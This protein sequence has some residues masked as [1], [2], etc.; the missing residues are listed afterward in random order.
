MRNYLSLAVLSLAASLSFGAEQTLSET[1]AVPTSL[2]VN[3]HFNSAK[4][5]EMEMLAAGGFKWVRMDMLWN[6]SWSATEKVKG[7][8]DFSA[9][10]KLVESLRPHGIRTICIFAYANPLYDQGLSPFTDEGRNAYA[11][12]AVAAAKHFSGRGILFE[13]WN[14][15]NGRLFWKP[16]PKAEDYAKLAV[17]VGKA[18]KKEVPQEKLVG[19]ALA[20]FDWPFMETCFKAGVLEYWSAVTVHPYRNG[21]PETVEADYRKLRRM[22]ARY[23]P[24][25]K[26]IPIIS[27]EW[28]YFLNLDAAATPE[29]QGKF[30]ARQWLTNLANEIPVSIWYDWKN[31]GKNPKD[32]EHNLGTVGFEYLPDK[33][34]VYQPK[35]AYIAAQALTKALD[36]FRFSKRILVGAP[37]DHIL[38]FEKDGQVRLAAW[39]ER[40]EHDLLVPASVGSFTATSHL[41]ELLPALTADANGLKIHLNDT[42]Q[43]L[44]P[45]TPNDYLSLM[46]AWERLPLD[47][48]VFAPGKVQIKTS[49][50]NVT[51][52]PIRVVASTDQ[53]LNLAPGESGTLSLSQPV[54][55]DNPTNVRLSANVEGVGAMIQETN[56]VLINPFTPVLMPVGEKAVMLRM[57]NPRGKAFAGKIAVTVKSGEKSITASAAFEMQTTD[58]DKLVS[59]D[60]PERL[61]EKGSIQ[62][63]LTT[64][65]GEVV[66]VADSSY[67]SDLADGLAAGSYSIWPQKDQGFEAMAAPQPPPSARGPVMKLSYKFTEAQKPAGTQPSTTQAAILQPV[68]TLT[69]GPKPKQDKVTRID[70]KPKS[71]LIWVYGDGSGNNT[72]ARFADST[73]AIFQPSGESIRWKGW[74]CVSFTLDDGFVWHWGGAKED[75]I[76]YPIQWNT[77]FLMDAAGRKS[78]AGSIYLSSPTVIW[79]ER[80]EP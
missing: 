79:D 33:Q 68:L 62:T 42:P 48:M 2:G 49:I 60:M 76:K 39:T 51:A 4:P 66:A 38:L 26:H 64:A 47:T 1:P 46:G 54:T 19:P 80:R 10:D 23:A 13:N 22:I 52:K 11:A 37:A 75:A 15:P 12:W 53:T 55:S 3:I 78:G 28:G 44:A 30:L 61:P 6:Q 9:F 36:G 8:Y 40:G 71:L 41:G 74:R 7:V 58:A 50:R 27:G 56:V 69:V 31:D 21:D 35:P 57:E 77:L 45:Q 24:E 5:G 18:F 16:T 65:A 43:Y 70:G 29:R 32:V 20:K 73:G 67:S 17:T 34:P 63:T 59:L 14:E 72:C 25:G